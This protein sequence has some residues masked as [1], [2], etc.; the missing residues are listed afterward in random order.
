MNNTVNSSLDYDLLPFVRQAITWTNTDV[1]WIGHPKERNSV[2]FESK[3]QN[4]L[5]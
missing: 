5:L 3:Y 4:F 1:L 2:K